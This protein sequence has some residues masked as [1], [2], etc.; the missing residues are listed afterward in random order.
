MAL[1]LFGMPERGIINLSNCSH[2]ELQTCN[3]LFRIDFTKGM[4]ANKEEWNKLVM[5]A[6]MVSDNE[7]QDAMRFIGAWAGTSGGSAGGAGAGPSFSF[8]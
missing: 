4:V 7:I 8:Q 3:V 6:K 2:P 1:S 5:V